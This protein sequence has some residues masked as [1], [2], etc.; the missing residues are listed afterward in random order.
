VVNFN[1]VLNRQQRSPPRALR[2]RGRSF[3]MEGGRSRSFEMA[4]KNGPWYS[5]RGFRPPP[6]REGW[7]PHG[8]YHG[9]FVVV[10]L[11][12]VMIWFVLTPLWRKWFDTGFTHL[13][14]TPVLSRLFTH[15][16]AF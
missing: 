9:G 4:R 11:I 6:A 2:W 5:F 3:E 13:V 15:V 16:L 12:G 10:A 7:F 14:L 8:G 1:T